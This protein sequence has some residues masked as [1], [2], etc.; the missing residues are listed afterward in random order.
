MTFLT[1]SQI[2]LKQVFG[3]LIF[4]GYDTSR[5][6]EN[7]VS[8]SMADDLT[9]DLVVALQSISYSGSDKTTL[10]SSPINI[11]IDSTDP[12]L[13]LPDDV[14]D[15]FESAFGLTVDNTTGLYLVNDTHHS[16]LVATDAEVSFR[17]SDVLEGG[18]SVT[19][20]LPYDAFA[21]KAEYPLVENISYYFPL[22]RAAN[23]TQYT[24]GRVFLQEA[25]LT[26]DYERQVFNVSQCTWVEGAEE[27][28]V[29]IT[30][31]DANITSSSSAS[32][33][34]TQTTETTKSNSSTLSNGTITG[35]VIACLVFLVLVAVGVFF[36]LRHRKAAKARE[37]AA[38][39]D[40]APSSPES[41][42]ECVDLSM[43]AEQPRAGLSN[44]Y[45]ELEGDDHHVYQL[46]E[47]PR[48]PPLETPMFELPGSL[49]RRMELD[50]ISTATGASQDNVP[51]GRPS[52]AIS[53]SP[54]VSSSLTH[55]PSPVSTPPPLK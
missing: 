19:I 42:I 2:G 17:L 50:A 43:K 12:N 46:H 49:G 26:A 6:T 13:W 8:F 34:A 3:Q 55:I 9:R 35:T 15:A 1:V 45:G 40:T 38:A 33:S 11:Y 28:I 48:R 54:A 29:T 7:S 30:S 5:F 32:A 39:V 27:N 20:V 4:S 21:L 25:Y 14:C 24:L 10:L 37:A 53:P 18:D 36:F 41:G 31:K 51:L 47:E 52:P 44:V 16:T 22:K 23:E